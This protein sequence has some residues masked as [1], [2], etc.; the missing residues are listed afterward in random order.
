MY[1]KL[2]QI[3]IL[4]ISIYISIGKIS[5]RDND[6]PADGEEEPKYDGNAAPDYDNAPPGSEGANGAEP[7]VGIGLDYAG[8]NPE[9]ANDDSG[10]IFDDEGQQN[11]TY[12]D[13]DGN[14]DAGPEY[15]NNNAYDDA[16]YLTSEL[17]YDYTGGKITPLKMPG[18]TEM[19]D[20]NTPE[21]GFDLSY[22]EMMKLKMW[23]DALIPY[24]IDV[25][26]F[27]GK[28]HSIDYRNS[29]IC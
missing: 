7:N 27:N 4:A 2:L 25:Y 15:E 24:Y 21:L 18:S 14:D 19:L 10:N 26:S 22:D 23:P 8:S 11:A 3:C 20:R 29:V 28:F 6:E 13:G 16:E 17:D 9:D 5:Y 12:D 1:A